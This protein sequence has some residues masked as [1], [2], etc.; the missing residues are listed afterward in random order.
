AKEKAKAKIAAQKQ[1][2]QNKKAAAA[3][4]RAES[5]KAKME[6]SKAKVEAKQPAKKASKAGKTIASIAEVE[7]PK[8][9]PL[10]D[11]TGAPLDQA[12]RNAYKQKALSDIAGSERKWGDHV[13]TLDGPIPETP[14]NDGFTLAHHEFEGIRKDYDEKLSPKEREATLYYSSYGDRVLNHAMR[15]GE[16]DSSENADVRERAKDLDAAISKHTMAEDTQ[17][18][19][20][21]VG[22]WVQDLVKSLKPGSVFRDQGYT[23]TSATKALAFD[24]A[25]ARTAVM[26]IKIPKGAKAAPLP[27]RY[28]TETEFLL[29]RGSRFRVSSIKKA[30]NGQHN[31]ELELV[32]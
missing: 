14:I 29:P 22:P 9:P 3:L 2:L 27:T 16:I 6:K 12:A 17:V 31:I 11:H 24:E 4:K 15:S 13:K 28:P 7:L 21:V 1:K 5:A 19:R 8:A 30:K 18:S 25:P 23:S 10:T 26:S 20:V 32:P